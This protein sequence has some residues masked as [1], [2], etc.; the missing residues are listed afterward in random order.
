M[1]YGDIFYLFSSALPISLKFPFVCV[2]SIFVFKGY[3]LLH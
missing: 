3:L 1:L 2:L